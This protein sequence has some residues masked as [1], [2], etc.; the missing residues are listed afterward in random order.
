LP[1]QKLDLIEKIEEEV[2]EIV[3][4]AVEAN[5]KKVTE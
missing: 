5:S 3:I 2:R 1:K 4:S